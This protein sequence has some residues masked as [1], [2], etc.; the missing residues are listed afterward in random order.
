MVGLLPLV[1]FS[2]T[3]AMFTLQYQNSLL[4]EED[5]GLVE[6]L[7]TGY[8]LKISPLYIAWAVVQRVPRIISTP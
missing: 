3:D 7:Q 8:I 2:F 4:S 5:I 6:G 1:D